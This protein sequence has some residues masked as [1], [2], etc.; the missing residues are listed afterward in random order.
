MNKPLELET[1][2]AFAQG[3]RG[4][5]VLFA[6]N[7]YTPEHVG[8]VAQLVQLLAE[9][10]V[11]RGIPAAV[12]TLREGDTPPDEWVNGVRVFRFPTTNAY[13]PLSTAAGRRGIKRVR[14]RLVD[15][16]GL[17]T[18]AGIERAIVEFR[19]TLAHTHQLDG[20]STTALSALAR[21]RL[22]IVHTLHDYYL[23]CA[24][25][26]RW[27]D[28][29]P[30][31]RACALCRATRWRKTAPL[32]SV[33][34]VV[35][36]SAYVLDAHLRAGFFGGVEDAVVHPGSPFLEPEHGPFREARPLT[37]GFIGPVEKPMGV[38]TLLRATYDLA[39]LPLRVRVAGR[40][41]P[42][43]LKYLLAE[44][45]DARVEYT[46]AVAPSAFFKT[47]DVAIWPALWE[48]P[49]GS[50]YQGYEY[51]IPALGSRIGGVPETISEGVT[52]YLFNPGDHQALAEKMKRFVDDP[53][54]V[55]RFASACRS[56]RGYFTPERM[57]SEY[58]AIYRR[59]LGL[60]PHDAVSSSD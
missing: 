27:H 8:G 7:G 31:E 51:G 40:V 60:K 32:E 12:L 15:M 59:A 9:G 24:N 41:A 42:P 46:G 30:R 44:F 18:N 38:E 10:L 37:F 36:D 29:G 56:R 4:L 25:S 13:H 43:Y 6:T 50:V 34:R 14:Y 22:P 57:V 23:L 33:T 2:S 53:E 16:L 49:L 28:G 11:E 58:L 21:S 35:G 55:E 45:P 39:G 17:R 20:F 5:R 1:P 52:G 26:L 48:D 54:S 3:T 19:P 47:I